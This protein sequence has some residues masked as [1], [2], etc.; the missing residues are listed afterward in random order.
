VQLALTAAAAAACVHNFV[1]SINYLI[2]PHAGEAHHG[3]AAG[4]RLAVSFFSSLC[5]FFD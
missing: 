4:R 5:R 1:K 3:N 2:W